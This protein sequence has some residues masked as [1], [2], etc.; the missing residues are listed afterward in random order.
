MHMRM[1]PMQFPRRSVVLPV[2]VGSALALAACAAPGGMD[3]DG[4]RVP[5]G[6]DAL[7][8]LTS[9][10][11]LQYVT[12]RIG[13]PD[14]SVTNLTP[15][16]AEPHDLELSPVDILSIESSDV[17]VYL[18]GF[19]PAIDDAIAQTE[20]PRV[21]D[22][23]GTADL[24]EDGDPHFW[25]DPIRLAVVGDTIA[26][27]LAEADPQDAATFIANAAELRGDLTDLDEE[28]STT[29]A[30]CERDVVVVSHEAFGYL[31]GR[32][33]LEQVGISGLDPE[34]EPSP[35]RLAE[36]RD[37]VEREGVTTV[38]TETLVSPKVAEVIAADLGVD[39]ATL[40]PIEGLVDDSTDYLAVMRANLEALTAALGC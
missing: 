39:V 3:G 8:V 37:I 33:D 21:L 9:F 1:V 25:L 27:T 32:Y 11:P 12:E 15:R 26:A 5:G 35:A 31:T 10:Y 7:Q 18:S 30:T 13:G 24:Q 40:D 14:V 38:F 6:T 28:F 22:V 17:F 2:A 29:L 19:Q 4:G 34:S 16:G 20:G 23:A 36:I